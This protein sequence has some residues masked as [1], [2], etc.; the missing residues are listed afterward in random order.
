ME[1]WRIDRPLELD[2]Y[3]EVAEEGSKREVER[4]SKSHR[5]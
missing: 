3:E 4:E 2:L 1:L 5:R